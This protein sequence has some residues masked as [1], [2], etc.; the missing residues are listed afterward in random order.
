MHVR[1]LAPP[2]RTGTVIAVIGTGARAVIWVAL[3]G[4]HPVSFTAGQIAPG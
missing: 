4:W 1:E 3:T 2:H